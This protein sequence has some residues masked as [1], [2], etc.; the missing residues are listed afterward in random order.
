[1]SGGDM[2]NVDV[3]DSLSILI[4][5]VDGLQTKLDKNSIKKKINSIHKEAE[6]LLV[7]E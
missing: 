6:D 5:A 2:E 1:V 7:A 4:K 3:E